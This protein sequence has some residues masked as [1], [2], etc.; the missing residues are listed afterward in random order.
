[1]LVTRAAVSSHPHPHPHPPPGPVQDDATLE[2]LQSV[3]TWP[4]ALALVS[5]QLQEA[6]GI[7]AGKG[8]APLVVDDDV[9]QLA[10][11]C[12]RGG[13]AQM[14]G[15]QTLCSTDVNVG[16]ISVF[17]YTCLQLNVHCAPTNAMWSAALR[18]L[19]MQLWP[20]GYAAYAAV[21]CAHRHR[22]PA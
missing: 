9:L 2:L 5:S 21:A 19:P 12:G 10:H 18:H 13:G 8:I 22:S 3:L 7:S 1:M 17:M 14:L 4:G 6:G 16:Y 11:R 15:A 20:M